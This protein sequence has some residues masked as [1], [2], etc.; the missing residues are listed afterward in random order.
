MI[1]WRCWHRKFQINSVC[2]PSSQNLFSDKKKDKNKLNAG[3]ITFSKA[4]LDYLNNIDICIYY[5]NSSPYA[6]RYFLSLQDFP[7][8]T[9]FLTISSKASEISYILMNFRHVLYM[10]SSVPKCSF[11][12]KM[13]KDHISLQFLKFHNKRLYQKYQLLKISK[14]HYHKQVRDKSSEITEKEKIK[15][16]CFLP[17]V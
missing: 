13:L 4:T 3:N 16:P 17:L 9:V 2:L 11:S 15:L 14:L 5:Q 8:H 7:E 6:L 1:S 12:S 10:S